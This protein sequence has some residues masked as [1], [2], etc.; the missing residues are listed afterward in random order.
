VSWRRKRLDGP[1]DRKL[2]IADWIY[3]FRGSMKLRLSLHI[4][5]VPTPPPCFLWMLFCRVDT[6]GRRLTLIVSLEAISCPPSSDRTERKASVRRPKRT[7]TSQNR[8]WSQDQ[9]P[10]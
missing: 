2:R 8:S 10:S 9:T 7:T 4:V 5:L 6:R 1:P 3:I